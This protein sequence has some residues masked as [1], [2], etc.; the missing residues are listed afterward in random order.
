MMKETLKSKEHLTNMMMISPLLLSAFG[1]TR[2]GEEGLTLKKG[3][4]QFWLEK[5][6]YLGHSKSEGIQPTENKVRAIRDAPAPQS[7]LQLYLFCKSLW[8]VPDGHIEPTDTTVSLTPKESPM[9]KW[10][11]GDK[12]FK[13]V[14]Q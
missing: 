11:H 5:V 8:Q 9:E 2:L 6:E 12:V 4:H 13:L 7:A 14:R 3:K 1:L 10:R